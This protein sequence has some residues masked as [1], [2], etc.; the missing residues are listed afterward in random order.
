MTDSVRLRDAV[1]ILCSKHGLTETTAVGLLLDALSAGDL[2]GE[3]QMRI[4]SA[5][6]S[7]MQGIPPDDWP[8]E[9]QMSWALDA[10][11][12]GDQSGEISF[13][14]VHL[15]GFADW[16]SIVSSALAQRRITMDELR[17]MARESGD[18]GWTAFYEK[19]RGRPECRGLKRA[20]FELAW[21]SPHG[22]R[23][24]GRPKGS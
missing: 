15:R 12:I 19:H 18:R 11:W 14:A 2:P 7:T 3:A 4:G 17:S 13:M 5:P 22:A 24:S 23:P 6:F 8:R 9:A 10:D 20:D 16:L 1:G 21:K